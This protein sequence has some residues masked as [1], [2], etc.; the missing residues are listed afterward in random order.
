M[1]P[2][3]IKKAR[4]TIRRAFEED[5][6][7]KQTYIANVAMYLHDEVHGLD[8]EVKN[9]RESKAEKLIDMLFRGS[10]WKKP[11]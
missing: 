8:M 7:F 11:K 3:K 10:S 5:P 1:K 6:E 9:I 4:R 2:K